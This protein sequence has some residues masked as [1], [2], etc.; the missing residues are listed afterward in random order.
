MQQLPYEEKGAYAT[1]PAGDAAHPP[2]DP[3]G[4]LMKPSAVAK[5]T[6]DAEFN[7]F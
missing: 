4:H 6:I 5:E 2:G 3:T 1:L 7:P